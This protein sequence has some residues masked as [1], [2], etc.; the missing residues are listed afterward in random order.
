MPSLLDVVQ[1]N[2]TQPVS[3]PLEDQTQKARKLLAARSG[4]STAGLGAESSIAEQAAVEQTGQGLVDVQRQGQLGALELTA[5]QQSTQAGEQQSRAELDLKRRQ[6]EQAASRQKQQI[7]MQLGQ[8]RQKLTQ[9]QKLA[10][11]EQL[12]HVMRLEDKKYTDKLE[13]KA[14]LE[15][16]S[17]SLKFREAQQKAIFGSNLELLKQQLGYADLLAASERDFT[18][19]MADIDLN[20]ALE[21]MDNQMADEREAAK[22]NAASGIVSSSVNA[23]D[24]YQDKKKT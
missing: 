3:A 13:M 11:A 20:F 21:V 24:K 12:A 4:K 5:K 8:E 18:E 17:N 7:L 9:D 16:L 2:M 14:K 19:R 22:I 1:Q 23:Y 6:I 10:R 15:N